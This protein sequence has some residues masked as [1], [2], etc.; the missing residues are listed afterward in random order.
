MKENDALRT[1]CFHRIS[2][3]LKGINTHGLKHDGEEVAF[4][5]QKRNVVCCG[6]MG[7]QQK[8]ANEGEPARIKKSFAIYVRRPVVSMIFFHL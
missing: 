6:D 2:T 8:M 5:P 3:C 1:K 7:Y 4:P